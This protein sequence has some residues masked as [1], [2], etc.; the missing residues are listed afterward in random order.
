MN[1]LRNLNA[2]CSHPRL[3]HRK[4]RNSE[5]RANPPQ[6]RV[7]ASDHPG[8]RTIAPALFRSPLLRV[9]RKEAQGAIPGH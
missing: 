9:D 5:R 2:T 6:N 3:F 1:L 8:Y 4:N 7:D